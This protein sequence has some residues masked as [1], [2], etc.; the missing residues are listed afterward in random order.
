MSSVYSSIYE[1]RMKTL[2]KTNPISMKALRFILGISSRITPG[3]TTK[4][5]LNHFYKP[6]VFK[7]RKGTE[8]LP[9]TKGIE[10]THIFPEYEI[11]T[12]TYGTG[13]TIL[14]LHG[15]GGSSD[16]FTSIIDPLVKNGYQVI[17]LD[18]PGHGNSSGKESSLFDFIASTTLIMNT[19]PEVYAIIGHSIGGLAAMNLVARNQLKLKIVTISAP[20]SIKTIIDTYRLNLN[21]SDK[22]VNN[23]VTNIEKKFRVSIS[24]YAVDGLYTSFPDSG[25]IIHDKYDYVIPYGE[26]EIISQRWKTA[27]LKSVTR[28]GHHRI[29]KEPLITKEILNYL[30]E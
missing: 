14:C 22:V 2:H 13:P 27:K 16:S 12:K 5:L 19:V 7:A 26:S 25:L 17:T 29:L 28:L 9:E 10:F 8:I 1:K 21:L 18:L 20:S 3:L 30:N 15:W 11:N 4:I 23:L 24:D 6:N